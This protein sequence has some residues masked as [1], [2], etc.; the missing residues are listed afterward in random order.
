[1]LGAGALSDLLGIG[2][3]PQGF[4]DGSGDEDTRRMRVTPVQQ[5]TRELP[6]RYRYVPGHDE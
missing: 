5:E 6:W 2:R 1:M 3:E 4:G